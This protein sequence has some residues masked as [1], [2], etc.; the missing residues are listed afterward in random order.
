MS[1]NDLEKLLELRRK[2]KSRKPEFLRHLW[3]KKPK[4]KNKPK[5]RKPKGLDNKMRL[6]LKGY[7]PV[8]EIGYRGPR[9]VRGYH[10]SGKKPVVVYSVKD[11]EELDPETHIIYIGS[12]VGLR[13]RIELIKIA[14]EKGFK[15]AN[16]LHST[17]KSGGVE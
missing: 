3:W 17:V 7:P 1:R 15:V 10:P 13:K 12:T 9:P 16:L 6:K 2:L 5:W 4:F 8:V 11:L 14:E